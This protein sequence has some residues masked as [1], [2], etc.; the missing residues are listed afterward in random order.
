MKQK[1]HKDR[2]FYFGEAGKAD[3][4]LLDDFDDRAQQSPS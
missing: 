3:R 1:E 4:Y 2:A